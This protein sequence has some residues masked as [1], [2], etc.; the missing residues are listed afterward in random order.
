MDAVIFFVCAGLVV[1]GALGVITGR[2]PVH[3]ALFLLMALVSI[4]VLYLQLAAAL[5]A[6]IQIVVYASAIVVLFL[7]VVTLLP[8]GGRELEPG[9][10]RVLMGAIAGA[11]LLVAIGAALSVGAPL[12][13][14]TADLGISAVGHA[15]FGPLLVA[16][17]LTAPLL[18]VAMIGAVVVWR[19]HEPR[20]R[21]AVKPTTATEPR[22]LVMHR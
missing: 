2:N 7:F 6:A 19:R 20:P 21:V 16:F 1:A 4:A 9:R 12:A 17:E 15:L 3:C 11:S 5:V 22:R 18:L 8:T 13:V 10:S 14:A